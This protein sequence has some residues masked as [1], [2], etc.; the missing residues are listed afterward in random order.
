M[1]TTRPKTKLLV[2]G[3]E[4]CMCVR[5]CGTRERGGG[6]EGGRE[7]VS[8]SAAGRFTKSTSP[9]FREKISHSWAAATWHMPRQ[10]V[11]APV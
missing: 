4:V 9:L 5:V 7:G 10:Q 6:G 3:A 2:C 1:L 8:N 11:D